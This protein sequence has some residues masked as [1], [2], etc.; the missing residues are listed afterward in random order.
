MI[1]Q[2]H[3]LF[4][5]IQTNGSIKR[6]T[7]RTKSRQKSNQS[8]HDTR[9][10]E[11]NKQSH[12]L[13]ASLQSNGV[14]PTSSIK[15]LNLNQ[16]AP[17]TKMDKV[18]GIDMQFIYQKRGLSPDT[19]R[20]WTEKQRLLKTEKTRIVR[21]GSNHERLQEYRLTQQARKQIVELNIQIYDRFFH[22]CGTLGTTP[23]KEYQQNNHES[24]IIQNL[25]DNESQVSNI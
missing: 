3:G 2:I 13:E 14:N 7:Q 4:D 16:S 11:Q 21:K 5:F 15:L 22:F 24:W 18:N 6:F 20:L 23:L 8:Q 12:S 1:N 19:Y 25:S 17:D 9:K 10:R